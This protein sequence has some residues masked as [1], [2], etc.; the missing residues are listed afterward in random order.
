MV[1]GV[2]FGFGNF[3]FF[4]GKIN[5]VEEGAG[6]GFVEGIGE[7]VGTECANDVAN[8]HGAKISKAMVGDVFFDG[9]IERARHLAFAKLQGNRNDKIAT[10]GGS[11]EDALTVRELEVGFA[12][13]DKVICHGIVCFGFN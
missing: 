5:V 2:T 10:F 13:G 9:V 6:A 7:F 11:V 3:G 1:D 8:A 4:C 12:E